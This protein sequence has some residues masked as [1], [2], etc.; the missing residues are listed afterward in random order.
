[1]NAAL[2]EDLRHVH[3]LLTDKTGALTDSRSG[4]GDPRGDRL[5]EERDAGD[6]AAA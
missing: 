1:V 3:V 4:F 6:D 5:D 2:V